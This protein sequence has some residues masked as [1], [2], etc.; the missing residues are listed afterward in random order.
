MTTFH[1]NI[2]TLPQDM[3]QEEIFSIVDPKDFPSIQLTCRKF[4]EC[5][6]TFIDAQWGETKKLTSNVIPLQEMMETIERENPEDSGLD[7]FKRLA[8]CFSKTFGVAIISKTLPCT[9][10]EIAEMQKRAETIADESLV[11]LWNAIQ[12][13]LHLSTPPTTAAAIRTWMTNPANAGALNSITDL[14][15]SVKQLR[16]IPPEIQ[17]LTQL[18]RLNFVNNQIKEIP[19][20][21]RFLTQL[22]ELFLSQ[23]Q[24]KEIPDAIRFRTQLR[25]LDLS[26][27]QITVIPEAI[28]TLTQLQA[29]SA[30]TQLQ[31]RYLYQNQIT[32]IPGAISALTQLRRPDVSHNQ[33]KQRS[34]LSCLI[35]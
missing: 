6:A 9:A 22:Q 5:S 31:S 12:Q 8:K 2:C 30:H 11:T 18:Q 34:C 33:K 7:C 13:Q 20:T 17:F 10:K 3:F 26:H 29:I 35:A 23:N 27:N 4:K 1:T 14:N 25:R 19:E 15:V 28:K 32:V 21:I 16:T 24:I